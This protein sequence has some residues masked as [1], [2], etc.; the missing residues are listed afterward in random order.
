M[1]ALAIRPVQ[2]A[3]LPAITAIYEHAVRHGTR[4]APTYLNAGEGAGWVRFGRLRRADTCT[5]AAYFSHRA[6]F[7]GGRSATAYSDDALSWLVGFASSI[8]LTALSPRS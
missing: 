3:D 2:E 1:S 4:A 5:A 7:S 8:F 6:L